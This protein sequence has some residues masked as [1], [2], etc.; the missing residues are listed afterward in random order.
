MPLNV[1]A[2]KIYIDGSCLKNPGG[3][4]GFAAW[5]EHPFDST[6]TPEKLTARGYFRTTNNRME[7]RACIFAH[8]WILARGREI[9]C[10]HVQIATDSTYVFD[11]HKS[12]IQWS[13]SQW[14]TTDERE[15]LNS[16]LWK[17]L[18]RLR[19]KIRSQPR[20]ETVLIRRRS[21]QLAKNVDNDAKQA[22]RSPQYEDSGYKPGK[23]GRSRNSDGKAAKPYPTSGG[24]VTVLIYRTQPA[25]RGVQTVRFQTY[26][27]LRRD[28]FDKF[29]ANVEDAVGN[30]LHRGNVYLV[31]MNDAPN[32]PRIL[33]VVSRLNKADFIGTKPT[34]E[35]DS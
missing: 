21:T 9:G 18:I 27:E 31:R 10:Q 2:L 15:V 11:G 12:C 35:I 26:C 3:P 16:D 24:E 8:E 25:Q 14:S 17:E 20:V 33:Q 29:W 13:Q 22:A 19:R 7:L 1:W 32:N 5:L 4:G 30:S 28:F 6:S 34:T 23:T